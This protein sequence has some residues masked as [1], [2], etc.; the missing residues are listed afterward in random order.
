MALNSQTGD[1]TLAAAPSTLNGQRHDRISPQQDRSQEPV[2]TSITQKMLSAVTGS[3]LTSLLGMSAETIHTITR[4]SNYTTSHTSR[5]RSRSV[6][7]TTSIKSVSLLS[8]FHRLCSPP[9]QYWCLHL[10][11]RGI[12][13]SKSKPILCCCAQ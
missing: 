2:E 7:I 9:T 12:L 3:I 5:C 11:S 6:T 4:F 8:L 1:S 10:L 13:G